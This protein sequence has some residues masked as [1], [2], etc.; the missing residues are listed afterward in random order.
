MVLCIL[1]ALAAYL[2]L[3]CEQIDVKSAFPNA[4]IEEEIYMEQPHGFTSDP[5]LVCKLNKALYGL[6]QSARQWYRFL[7]SLL[8]QLGFTP[9]SSDQSVFYNAKTEVIVASHIDD[10]LIFGK[11]SLIQQ[12]K[13]AISAQVEI[14]DLGP[15]S[16][17]LG[18]E[19]TRDPSNKSITMS[20]QKYT[21][22][23]LAKFGKTSLKSVKSPSQLGVRLEKSSLVA[24][25]PAVGSVGYWPT[26]A[27]EAQPGGTARRHSQ[28]AKPLG[29]TTKNRS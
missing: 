29:L 10:L 16:Y 8:K 7:A 6:K 28:E 15:I 4:P 19:I 20:Q 25:E 9:I 13:K 23:I 14:T 26:A 22:E 21:A 24:S 3:E 2:G 11:V 17:Y 27:T 1:F 12:L 5:A 18:I